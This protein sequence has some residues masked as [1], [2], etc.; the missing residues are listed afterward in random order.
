[1]AEADNEHGILLMHAIDL[2]SCSNTSGWGIHQ[3]TNQGRDILRWASQLCT[4]IA[5]MTRI[6]IDRAQGI[7]SMCQTASIWAMA[8]DMPE[9]RHGRNATGLQRVRNVKLAEPLSSCIP[10]TLSFVHRTIHIRCRCPRNRRK[11]HGEHSHRSRLMLVATQVSGQ[12][13]S[14]EPQLTVLS[15]EAVQSGEQS[16]N[17]HHKTWACSILR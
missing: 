2:D 6:P 15:C 17:L 12:P 10:L 16:P 11:S 13:S 1:L 9:F 5:L 4:Y 3:S 7:L 14:P 8:S